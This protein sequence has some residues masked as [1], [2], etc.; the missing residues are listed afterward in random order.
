MTTTSPAIASAA[1][2]AIADRPVSRGDQ[3]R[4]MKFG[5]NVPDNDDRQFAIT[6]YTGYRGC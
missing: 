4:K 2:D 5:M 3:E 6:H 1:L